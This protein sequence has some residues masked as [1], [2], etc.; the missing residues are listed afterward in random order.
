MN[1]RK[2]GKNSVTIHYEKKLERTRDKNKEKER[3]R[4]KFNCKTSRIF[5]YRDVLCNT[6]IY[7]AN[8]QTAN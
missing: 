6:R 5:T 8:A 4:K 2:R 7:H 3:S 1:D